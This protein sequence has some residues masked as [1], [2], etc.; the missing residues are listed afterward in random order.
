MSRKLEAAVSSLPSSKGSASDSPTAVLPSSF[1]VGSVGVLAE[2]MA[3]AVGVD[4]SAAAIVL[5]TAV[6]AGLP[7]VPV[8]AMAVKTGSAVSVA[9]MAW[10]VEVGLSLLIWHLFGRFNGDGRFC[11][12]C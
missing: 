3:V 4:G 12:S 11:C 2:M 7:T 9:S 5:A 1:S 10:A 8:A 6:S